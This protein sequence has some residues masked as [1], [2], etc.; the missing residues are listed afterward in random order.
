MFKNKKAEPKGYI[1]AHAL[2]N[3]V[4]AFHEMYA[5]ICTQ[6]I[7]STDQLAALGTKELALL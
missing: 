5:A 7:S 6:K 4:C 3:C 2:F 1:S